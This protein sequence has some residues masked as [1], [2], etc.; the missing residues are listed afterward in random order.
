MTRREVQVAIIIALI[1][2]L[3]TFAIA[4]ATYLAPA[5][6]EEKKAE[7]AEKERARITAQMQQRSETMKSVATASPKHKE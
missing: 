3:G 4:V 6:A 1:G 2:L 7:L 5:H